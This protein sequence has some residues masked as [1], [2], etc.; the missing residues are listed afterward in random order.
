[1][2]QALRRKGCPES[3]ALARKRGVNAGELLSEAMKK[4]LE[5]VEGGLD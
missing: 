2:F 3:R 1:V 5:E 4:R